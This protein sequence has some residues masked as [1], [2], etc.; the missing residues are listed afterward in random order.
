MFLWL[1]NG[2]IRY[3]N[4]T[5]TWVWAWKHE[6]RARLK[7]TVSWWHHP[8]L[9]PLLPSYS[10]VSDKPVSSTARPPPTF[11]HITFH[12]CHLNCLI[13]SPYWWCRAA[14]VTLQGNGRVVSDRPEICRSRRPTNNQSALAFRCHVKSGYRLHTVI[15]CT[16]FHDCGRKVNLRVM[17]SKGKIFMVPDSHSAMIENYS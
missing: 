16:E 10:T 5:S 1:C 13:N 17:I 9:Y 12:C 6:T 8:L 14:A 3:Q 15:L 4:T 2:Y 7:F 11:L